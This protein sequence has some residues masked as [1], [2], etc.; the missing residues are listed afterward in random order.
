LLLL[1]TY[2]KDP[3]E[4][5]HLFNTIETVPSVKK[6]AE[7]ALQ[8]INKEGL[9][10]FAKRLIGFTAVEGIFFLGSFCSIFWLKKCGLMPGLTFSN[11]LISCDKGLHAE[12]ACLLYSMLVNKPSSD[13]PKQI[14]LEAIE[15]EKEFV[16][17]SLPVALIGMNVGLMCQYIEFV[18]DHLLVALGCDKHYNAMNPFPWMEL[19]SLKGKT[20]FFKC[21]VSEY[22][23]SGIKALS[24][25]DST[26]CMFT[27]DEEF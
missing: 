6:K 27:T 23:K 3:I 26:V 15:I 13:M 5:A 22:A 1:D 25:T 16:T 7:W 14:I 9:N 10:T 12:F 21:Q 11:E 17:E 4:K 24:N 18:A 20:N 19:M 2:V 8:W